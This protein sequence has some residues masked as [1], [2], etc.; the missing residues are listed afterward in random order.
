MFLARKA[1]WACLVTAS[2]G[3]A[4]FCMCFVC[5]RLE[6][7]LKLRRLEVTRF[8]SLKLWWWVVWSF[9][10]RFVASKFDSHVHR[11]FLGRTVLKLN[12]LGCP[13]CVSVLA[14]FLLLSGKEWAVPNVQIVWLKIPVLVVR[15]REKVWS[16]TSG[17]EWTLFVF[18]L[19]GTICLLPV[20]HGSGAPLK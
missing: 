5:Q 15:V 17:E 3:F 12:W 20:S 10:A 8:R 4:C 13:G 14:V 9:V 2:F 7:T 6:T 1:F 18:P 11:L 16:E 19:E